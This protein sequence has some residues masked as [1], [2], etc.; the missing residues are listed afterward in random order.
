[1]PLFIDKT[2]VKASS[3]N[4]KMVDALRNANLGIEGIDWYDDKLLGLS[5]CTKEQEEDALWICFDTPS[6]DGESVFAELFIDDFDE[7]YDN[8]EA[9]EDVT[10]DRIGRR[11]LDFLA[12]L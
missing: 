3:V 7:I 2:P 4:D 9:D 8:Q 5:T 11:I 1:M 12:S 6:E 10:R